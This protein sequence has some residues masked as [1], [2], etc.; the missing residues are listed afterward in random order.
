MKHVSIIRRVMFWIFFVISLVSFVL[1]CSIDDVGPGGMLD[2]VTF[3]FSAF[4]FG[5]VALML[6]NHKVVFRHIF[7][8]KSLITLIYITYTRNRSRR[9]DYLYDAARKA[10]TVSK[11]YK[12]MVRLYDVAN[13]N[14][15]T[16]SEL[17]E[18]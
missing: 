8:I 12:V 10:G 18:G 15:V 14:F 5:F 13:K 2:Y 6:Y 11:F 7:A 17:Y 1:L 9:Y 3:A 16:V 4:V